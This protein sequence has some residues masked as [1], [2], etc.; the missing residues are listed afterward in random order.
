[1]ANAALT[2]TEVE[3]LRWLLGY[4]NIGVDAQPYTPDGWWSMFDAVVVPHLTT[5]PQTS[6]TTAVVAG[7]V[8]T[9]TPESMDGIVVYQRLVVDVGPMLEKVTVQAA[10]ATSFSAYFANTHSSGGYPI[11]VQSGVT[12]A[13]EL[14][15]EAERLVTSSIGVGIT[16]T[17]GLKSVG[18]GE[19]EWFEAG[20]VLASTNKQLAG[21]VALLSSLLRIPVAGSNCERGRLEA[22]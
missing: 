6:S 14:M 17:A 5:A 11:C 4:G 1:M 21:V 18:K 13:R 7:M 16:Q 15:A 19:I 3:T 20:S 10:D 9:V 12:R 2:A 22:Y 8:N